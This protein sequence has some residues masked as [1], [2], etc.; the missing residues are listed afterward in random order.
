MFPFLNIGCYYYAH[1]EQSNNLKSSPNNTL[2]LQ[3]MLIKIYYVR[4]NLLVVDDK[5]GRV[6]GGDVGAGKVVETKTVHY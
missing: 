1:K 4:D 3:S 5:G 2:N 6:T